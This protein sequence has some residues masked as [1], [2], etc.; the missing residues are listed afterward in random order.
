MKYILSLIIAALLLAFGS[1]KYSELTAADALLSYR[2]ALI[3]DRVQS[4]EPN[5]GAFRPSRY[6]G[7]LLTRL[8][9]GGA[10]STF[11][12]TP[13][14]TPDGSLLTSAALGDFIV[15]TINPG[16]AN[17]EKIS[18]SAVSVSGSTATWTIIN[19]GLSFASPTTTLTANV[20]QHAIGE[21]VIISN[22][23][24][25]L[26][27]QYVSV[28]DTQT[29]SG[30]KTLS[31][32]AFFSV[33]AS[34]SDEC[35]SGTEYCTKAYVD[36]TAN[37]GAATST[38]TNGG[39]VELGTAIETASS[40][41]HGSTKP[42]VVQTKHATDTPTAPCAVAAT[43][44]VVVAKAGIGKVLTE[45]IDST[46]HY[47]F[48]SLF[49]TNAS[50]TNATSTAL[51][52][53]GSAF[54]WNGVN[55]RGPAA[56]SASS[57][58]L[59]ASAS[60]QA[61]WAYPSYHVLYSNPGTVQSTT[62]VTVAANSLWLNNKLNINYSMEG[63]ASDACS[64]RIGSGSATTTIGN[65]L[66]GASNAFGEVWWIPTGA[67]AQSWYGYRMTADN[68]FNYNGANGT[69]AFALSG[70]IYIEFAGV[71]CDFYNASVVLLT[72]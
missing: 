55:L 60:G 54:H 27:N 66:L 47:I 38:E 34:S 25:F 45:W 7:K 68:T 14:T 10:E 56:I 46:R 64:V 52:I 23:D 51:A 22:D 16:G 28:D 36:A 9:E 1:L 72:Y 26:Y 70:K 43:P 2:Q 39:I 24:Q 18:A 33:A 44:C 4:Q 15:I 40:T 17:E 42:T 6:T 65:Q 41:D 62:T 19:R 32:G 30:Q 35:V 37:A 61:T 13:G 50:T 8:Q 58:V 59:T 11:N 12:T 71:S 48:G 3:E 29:I 31:Q 67:S 69:T 53:S 5:L 20:E 57:T 49:A 21:A 63:G